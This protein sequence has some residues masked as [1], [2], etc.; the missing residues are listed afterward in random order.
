ME[1]RKLFGTLV[2]ICSVLT[3]LGL[4]SM[5]VLIKATPAQAQAKGTIEWRL[6]SAW[7]NNTDRHFRLEQ[8][9]ETIYQRSNGRLKIVVYPSFSLGFKIPTWFRDHKDGLIDISDMFIRYTGGEEPSFNVT[10]ANM[11]KSKE[12]QMQAVEAMNDFKK[13]VYKEVWNSELIATAGIPTR[14][15]AFFTRTKQ[16]KK[17]TDMKGMKIRVLDI[18]TKDLIEKFGAAAQFMPMTEL[19]LALKQ[20]VIDGFDSGFGVIYQIKLHEVVKYAVSYGLGVP[21]QD[22]IVVSAKVWNPLPDDLKKIVRDEWD[23]WAGS[24]KYLSFTGVTGGPE[25]DKDKELCEKAGMV[26][27]E[28]NEADKGM[29]REVTLKLQMDWVKST[30]GRTAE[31]WE[32]IKPFLREDERLRPFLK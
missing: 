30:G 3:I 15:G 31:A 27:S 29:I 6:N 17:L 24:L 12:Q 4:I 11:W 18:R 10:E 7:A 22:D 14:M 5:S 20:G 2:R 21:N 19:Y 28:L 1:K 13:K 26:T 9:C 32:I 16:L 23:K 25:G 8:T